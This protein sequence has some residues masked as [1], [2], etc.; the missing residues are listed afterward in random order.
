M[1]IERDT[2][3]PS[4]FIYMLFNYL[5][6]PIKLKEFFKYAGCNVSSNTKEDRKKKDD[7]LRSISK[8]ITIGS[9]TVASVTGTD[10]ILRSSSMQQ[11]ESFEL[12]QDR[13]MNCNKDTTG[14]VTLHTYSR[15]HLFFVS[16]SGI[17]RFWSPLYKS[18]STSQVAIQTINYLD[19]YIGH[20]CNINNKYLFYDI[21]V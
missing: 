1:C 10:R 2:K 17:I 3:T 4:N 9:Q 6:I 15:G 20:Y 8:Q 11:K 18:E 19:L 14:L 21:M 7:V 5:G 16:S 12:I 13:D